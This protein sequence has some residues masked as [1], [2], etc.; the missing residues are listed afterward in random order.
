MLEGKNAAVLA[1]VLAIFVVVSMLWS[2]PPVEKPS[3]TTTFIA[4]IIGSTTPHIPGQEEVVTTT[5]GMPAGKNNVSIPWILKV[6]LPKVRPKVS[7]LQALI[8]RIKGFLAWLSSLFTLP[9]E[10][11]RNTTAS[12]KSRG[13]FLLPAAIIASATLAILGA[14]VMIVRRRASKGRDVVVIG[15]RVRRGGLAE[16]IKELRELDVTPPEN[17]LV[18]TIKVLA[19]RLGEVTGRKPD[20][21]THREVL[22]L[23]KKHWSELSEDLKASAMNTVR[24]YELWRFAG[25]ELREEWLEEARRVVRSAG[26]ENGP[27]A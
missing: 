6:K 22:Q 9:S 14:Y 21:I 17:E 23:V 18:K 11:P 27:T 25:K 2:P 13:S 10:Q 4:P 26:G 7:F 12:S 5:A 3:V 19:T 15:K 20:V 16:E 24:N 8:D 1:L